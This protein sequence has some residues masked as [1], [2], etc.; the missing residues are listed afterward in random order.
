MLVIRLTLL[1]AA[2]RHGNWQALGCVHYMLKSIFYFL[3][4]QRNI[5]KVG[6]SFGISKFTEM[7]INT[8]Y[9]PTKPDKWHQSKNLHYE[10]FWISQTERT[11]FPRIKLNSSHLVLRWRKLEA[12]TGRLVKRVTQLQQLEP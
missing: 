1:T 7:I 12:S 11:S 6:K 10:L 9:V 3:V 4:I 2:A 5:F 8:L